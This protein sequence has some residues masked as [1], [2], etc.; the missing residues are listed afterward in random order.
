MEPIVDV[1]KF[2]NA[3]RQILDGVFS[4]LFSE[5]LH[6]DDSF[7]SWP[8]PEWENVLRVR[9]YSCARGVRG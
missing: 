7:W 8:E 6:R 1:L 3:T 4:F 5:M 9:T 2:S